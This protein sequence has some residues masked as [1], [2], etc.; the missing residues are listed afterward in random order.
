MKVFC[1]FIGIL[2]LGISLVLSSPLETS[3]ANQIGA[4]VD[5]QIDRTGL[6]RRVPRCIQ[7]PGCKMPGY[8][9]SHYPFPIPRPPQP[10][11]LQ[12]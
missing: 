8:P 11:H 4:P 5:E 9:S 1:V 3:H 12:V 6:L 2:L 7:G 10:R